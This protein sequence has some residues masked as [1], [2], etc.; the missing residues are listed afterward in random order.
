MKANTDKLLVIDLECTCFKEG[1][2][3]KPEGW[4]VEKNMEI[5]EIGYT[6]LN[7]R[8]GKSVANG[9]IYVRSE[10]IAGEF[11]EELTGISD[12]MLN[13]F[14]PLPIAIEGLP[15]VC[16]NNEFS[17]KGHPWASWGDFDRVQLERECERKGVPYPF[18]K[19]HFN[20]K[21]L[22]AMQRRLNRGIGVSAALKAEGMLFQGHLHS[23]MDDAHNIG[24]LALRM[25]GKEVK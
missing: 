14:K 24:R 10:G 19:T 1:S 13:S 17:I 5:I 21:T 4:T 22:Y 25:L 2:P 15:E 20:L 11:C 3:D 16:G 18:G 23:G 12:S 6:I 8:I 7:L 9:G